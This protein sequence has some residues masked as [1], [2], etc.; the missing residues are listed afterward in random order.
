MAHP[1]LLRNSH[2]S[3][4]TSRMPSSGCISRT[5]TTTFSHYRPTFS[6]S[7]LSPYPVISRNSWHVTLLSNSNRSRARTR[8]CKLRYASYLCL[9]PV[10]TNPSRN[11]ASA[12]AQK[13]IESASSSYSLAQ[14][15]VHGLSDTMVAELKRVQT[16]TYQLPSQVQSSLKDVSDGLTTSIHELSSILS[17]DI[18]FNEKASKVKDTVQQKVQ[19]LLDATTSRVQEILKAISSRSQEAKGA[20]EEKV[21]EKTQNGTANGR[22]R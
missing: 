15:K 5:A 18:P 14:S 7:G 2:L 13:V 8:W 9:P 12:T 17:S 3:S 20:T 10:D 22:A 19:P 11:R 6:I 4:I 1:H 16:G 21:D